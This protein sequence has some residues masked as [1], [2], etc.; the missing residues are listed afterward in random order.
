MWDICLY[1]LQSV[2]GRSHLEGV[3]NSECQLYVYV[4]N[5]TQLLAN[6]HRLNCWRNWNR[7]DLII[8]GRWHYQ[9]VK[10]SSLK[11]LG[12][13][14]T[15]EGPSRSLNHLGGIRALLKGTGWLVQQMVSF[16]GM[17]IY[18]GE[19]YRQEGV[20]NL[21]TMIHVLILHY[22]QISAEENDTQKLFEVLNQQSEISGILMT[23]SKIHG[24]W[25]FTYWQVR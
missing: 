3:D 22:V 6:P 8:L 10:T 2:Q 20:I 23:L 18:L 12:P 24:P 19:K 7:G 11:W 4:Y 1:L 13:S 5:Y 17:E 9:L 16:S 21:C 14:Y 25:A 15:C